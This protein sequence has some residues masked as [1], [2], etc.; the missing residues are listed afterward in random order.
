MLPSSPRNPPKLSDSLEDAEV[1]WILR[2][3]E[4]RGLHSIKVKER[5]TSEKLV[6]SSQKHVALSLLIFVETVNRCQL[7]S[8]FDK[9]SKRKA[10]ITARCPSFSGW[11]IM[12]QIRERID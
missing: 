11:D 7:L 1:D 2:P 9:M 10:T 3:E 12:K 5:T 8:S 4:K 6:S